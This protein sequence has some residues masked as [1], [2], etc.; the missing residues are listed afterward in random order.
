MNRFCARRSIGCSRSGGTTSQPSRQ[1]VIEKYLEKE[2]TTIAWLVD[3]RRRR[4]IHAIG[5][6]VIDLVRD[7]ADAALAAIVHQRAQLRLR[8][9]C[10]DRVGRARDDQAVEMLA[11]LALRPAPAR[12]PSAG[13]L[14]SASIGTITGSMPSAVRMLR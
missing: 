4:R 6:A 10:A 8:H 7:E 1:P 13:Y 5:D 9:D 11:H 12:R 2:F 14:V 3:R